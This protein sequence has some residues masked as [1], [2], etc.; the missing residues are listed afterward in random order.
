MKD[1]FVNVVNKFLTCLDLRRVQGG[2]Q[3]LNVT[4]CFS[5]F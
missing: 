1:E 5:M 3:K 4:T 2:F